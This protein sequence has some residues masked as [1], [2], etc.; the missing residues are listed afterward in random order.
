MHSSEDLSANHTRPPSTRHRHSIWLQYYSVTVIPLSTE[1][2]LTSSKW[3]DIDTWKWQTGPPGNWE[4]S[5]WACPMLISSSC[6]IRHT[7]KLRLCPG[8]HSAVMSASDVSSC[9]ET[10]IKQEMEVG[11]E[12]KQNSCFTT[13]IQTTQYVSSLS[14]LHYET[15]YKHRDIVSFHFLD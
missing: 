12:D 5:R 14:Q 7:V 4:I 8:R 13:Q 11:L 15:V 3:T 6:C 1:V 9:R 10:Q 2:L